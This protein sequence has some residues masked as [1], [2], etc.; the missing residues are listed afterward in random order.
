MKMNHDTLRKI[1]LWAVLLDGARMWV[2]HGTEPTV[3]TTAASS[4]STPTDDM[5]EQS[6]LFSRMTTWVWGPFEHI[7]LSFFLGFIPV[8]GCLMCAILSYIKV[9][10]PMR[11][12]MFDYDDRVTLEKHVRV[13]LFIDLLAIC[14]LRMLKAAERRVGRHDERCA[15]AFSE[16]CLAS[17]TTAIDT[18]IYPATTD[19]SHSSISMATRNI[20]GGLIHRVRKTSASDTA[21]ESS[22]S[23]VVPTQNIRATKLTAGVDSPA[24]PIPDPQ[25]AATFSTLASADMTAAYISTT[26]VRAQ[27]PVVDPIPGQD[28]QAVALV[29]TPLP[30]P[31]AHPRRN[32]ASET[33]YEPYIPSPT[34]ST[35]TSSTTRPENVADAEEEEGEHGASTLTAVH[36]NVHV[37]APPDPF[38]VQVS[39]LAPQQHHIPPR[40]YYPQQ[41][42]L[43]DTYWRQSLPQLTGS[44]AVTGY[45][46]TSGCTLRSGSSGFYGGTNRALAGRCMSMPELPVLRW[47]NRD[48][49]YEGSL[50]GSES[51]D[52]GINESDFD[53]EE[54]DSAD[55][56][57]DGTDGDED[58][59]DESE[60]VED[61]SSGL[62]DSGFDTASEV[63]DVE[64]A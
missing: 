24:S 51:E 23:S 34:V 29:V 61:S 21:G 60:E 39:F 3:A 48:V 42:R 62:D 26:V 30:L 44:R 9:Y 41:G 25:D 6:S 18:V 13:C 8:I 12:F 16:S 37:Q 5:V 54:G 38:P 17:F 35:S 15:L 46:A 43:D 63:E 59:T 28:P 55:G 4:T 57:E 1:R 10:R 14:N 32:L 52:F 36:S 11:C 53:Q 50:G 47:R 58:S 19:V 40:Y 7:G 2:Y 64:D 45:G 49:M 27:E 56:D 22:M 31:G 33:V 20:T